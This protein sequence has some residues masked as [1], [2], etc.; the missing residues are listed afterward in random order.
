MLLVLYLLKSTDQTKSHKI[1]STNT[2]APEVDHDIS[3]SGH[4]AR[5]LKGCNI[6]PDFKSTEECI[7]NCL[8]VHIRTVTQD[9]KEKRRV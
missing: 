4:D 2:I 8:F 5:E 7:I 6:T 9:P 3:V 1:A